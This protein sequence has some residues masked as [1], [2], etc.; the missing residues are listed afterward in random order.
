RRDGDGRR[1]AAPIS[2]SQPPKLTNAVVTA[3]MDGTVAKTSVKAD[4]Y[5]SGSDEPKA[6][7]HYTLAIGADAQADVAW[8]LMWKG[9]NA[10]ALEAGLKFLLPAAT[11]RMSWLS[12]NRWTD[13]PP[14]HIGNPAA[15]AM[16]H[17]LSFRS[18]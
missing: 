7:L 11:D 2:N 10:V 12:E 9:T 16:S 4:V 6:Q 3:K 8:N 5:L 18:S 13:Y 17:D 15:S 1:G 14:D